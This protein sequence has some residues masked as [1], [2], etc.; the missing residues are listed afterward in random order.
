MTVQVDTMKGLVDRDQLLV[1]DDVNETDDT[2]IIQTVWCD[3]YTGEEVRRDVTV[4]ILRGL[5]V[6]KRQQGA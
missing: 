4:S 6:V 5:S 2:R 1:R 3:K